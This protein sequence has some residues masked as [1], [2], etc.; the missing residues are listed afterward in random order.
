MV[1]IYVTLGVAVVGLVILG[2]YVL[3][4]YRKL[5]AVLAELAVVAD[6]A[7]QALDLVAQVEVPEA[8]DDRFDASFPADRDHDDAW[9]GTD[10]RV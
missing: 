3:M 4:L 2:W 5:I 8:L 6:R 7:G 1:W 9:S 10:I